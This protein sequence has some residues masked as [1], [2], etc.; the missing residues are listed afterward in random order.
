MSTLKKLELQY[1]LYIKVIC[2]YCNSKDLGKKAKEIRISMPF[3]GLPEKI[4]CFNCDRVVD[5]RSIKTEGIE[6]Q[7]RGDKGEPLWK[8]K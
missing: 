4:R 1:E 5:I 2:P 7:D 8:K 6:I 3:R